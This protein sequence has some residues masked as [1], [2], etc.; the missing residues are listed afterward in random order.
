MRRPPVRWPEIITALQEGGLSLRQ[1]G[2]AIGGVP[3]N[4]LHAW[5]AGRPGKKPS[6]PGY[7]DGRALLDLFEMV[8]QEAEPATG[9]SL[10]DGGRP[11]WLLSESRTEVAC[12]RPGSAP[13]SPD[14]GAP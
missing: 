8:N 12:S 5:Q 9:S 3:A 13:R 11:S 7:E 2:Q 1:I 14:G 4:T 10:R 6:E